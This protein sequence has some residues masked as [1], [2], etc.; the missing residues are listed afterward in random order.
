[1]TNSAEYP[2]LRA[3]AIGHLKT[4][5]CLHARALL[6]TLDMLNSLQAC[7]R[8]Q[9]GLYSA[10]WWLEHGEEVREARESASRSLAALEAEAAP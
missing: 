4:C 6:A 8:Y 5:T 3:G 2:N 9:A 1:M 10:E 7:N